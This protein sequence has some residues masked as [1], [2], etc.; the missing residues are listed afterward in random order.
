VD[1]ENEQGDCEGDDTVAERFDS[2]LGHGAIP[3]NG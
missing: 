1:V 3:S 2:A